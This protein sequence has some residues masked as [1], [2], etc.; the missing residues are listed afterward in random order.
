M[1]SSA[2]ADFCGEVMG[3]AQRMGLLV[4]WCPDSR[5]CY[6]QKGFPDLTIVGPGGI[7]FAECKMPD[8]QTTAEQDRW[9]WMLSQDRRRYRNREDIRYELWFPVHLENGTIEKVLDKLR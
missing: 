4:H 3:L 8:G 9:G 2:E 6:G 7:L 1:A 5:K